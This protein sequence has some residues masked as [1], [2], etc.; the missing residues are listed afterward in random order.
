MEILFTEF[1]EVKYPSYD[2]IEQ[3]LVNRYRASRNETN[4]Y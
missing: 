4:L 3:K 1:E 2:Y